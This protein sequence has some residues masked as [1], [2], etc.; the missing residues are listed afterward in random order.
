[1]PFSVRASRRALPLLSAAVALALLGCT[2]GPKFHAP[3]PPAETSY[4]QQTTP[5]L[6]AG[7]HDQAQHL[8]SGQELREDW[9]AL[10]RSPELDATVRAAI[11]GNRT[12]VQAEA[13]LR[14][15]QQAEIEAGG[16]LYPQANLAAGA[17]RQRLDFATLGIPAGPEFPKFAEFNIFTVGPTVSYALDI[18][19]G[20]KRLIE[21]RHAQAEYQADQMAAAYLS[22]TGNAVTQAVTIASIHAQI[23]A[24]NDIIANDQQNLSLVQRELQAGMAT[25]IE[26]ESAQSQLEND[27]AFLP[28]LRQQLSAA[29]NALALLVGKSPADWSP[30]DFDLDRIALPTDLPVSLPAELV[31]RRPDILAAEAQIKAANA[32]VGVA[33]AALY[34][35]ITLSAGY[36]QLSTSL[37]NWF[38][39]YNNAWNIA[40][41]L[42]APLFHGGELTAQKRAA[43]A[44]ADATRA[45]Y[46]QTVLTAFSQIATVLDALQHDA[47]LAEAQHRALDTAQR[48]LNLTRTSYQG[49]NTGILL[50]LD[51]QRRYQQARLGYVRAVQQRYLDTVQLF[52][53][54]GG[55]WRQW[56]QSHQPPMPGHDRDQILK[57]LFSP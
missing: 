45:G 23:A 20:N 11:A 29:R 32:A 55:G 12:L 36:E 15:A 31:H 43:I 30:P 54:M 24:A 4:R 53:A 17:E 57:Q 14:Q 18:W 5:A 40:A 39:V 16:R 34:P 46:E 9:W 7:A 37:G 22:L 27:R 51:A 28:P 48:S 6:S 10:F 56:Q 26:V 21:E 13:N 3:A 47:E 38:A 44:A 35:N 8:T 41:N 25:Q 52:A 1:M 2:V 50:V 33:T 42:A 49:G 19:G